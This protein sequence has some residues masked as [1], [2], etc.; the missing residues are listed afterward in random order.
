MQGL[1]ESRNFPE[2]E[3][4][5]ARQVQQWRQAYPPATHTKQEAREAVVRELK[6]RA[7]EE[8]TKQYE[9]TQ[10]RDAMAQATR[11]RGCTP[12]FQTDLDELI[13]TTQP[14]AQPLY[15]SSVCLR[16]ARNGSFP[17]RC[18]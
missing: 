18:C 8:V 16:V 6:Q 5:Y 15:S 2:E 1:E 11:M 14:G 9:F 4:A 7:S 3:A 12:A 13:D 10:A 17:A